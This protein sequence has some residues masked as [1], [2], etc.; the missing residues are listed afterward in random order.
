MMFKACATIAD[1]Q[2]SL[3]QAKIQLEV[4]ESM[5][6]ERIKSLVKC[7]ERLARYGHDHNFLFFALCKKNNIDLHGGS[8]HL[9]LSGKA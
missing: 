4:Q 3:S 9:L 2:M 8:T 7:V 6:R 5:A 1:R